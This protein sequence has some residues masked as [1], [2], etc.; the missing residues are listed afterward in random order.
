MSGEELEE[1][2]F[3]FLRSIANADSVEDI[4]HEARIAIKEMERLREKRDIKEPYD[5]QPDKDGLV[6]YRVPPFPLREE[7]K[8]PCSPGESRR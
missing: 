5:F 1:C 7:N 4:K 8:P 6:D 3:D 2:F